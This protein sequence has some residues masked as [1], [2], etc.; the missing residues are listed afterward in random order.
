MSDFQEFTISASPHTP[1]ISRVSPAGELDGP[2]CTGF[3]QKLADFAPVGSC[4][5]IPH[6][7]GHRVRVG[8]LF[9]LVPVVHPELPF[10]IEPPLTIHTSS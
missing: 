2:G 8:A 3:A 1:C 6:P 7:A 5:H 4:D 10:H 9:W